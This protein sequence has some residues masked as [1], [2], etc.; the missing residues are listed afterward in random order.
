M[1]IHLPFA[2]ADEQDDHAT[3]VV[4]A[5]GKPFCVCFSLED[6]RTV[7]AAVREYALSRA[8]YEFAKAED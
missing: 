6:A 5:D 8:R 7:M 1:P 3:V 4:D 2:I